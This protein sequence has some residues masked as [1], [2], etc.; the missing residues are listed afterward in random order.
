MNKLSGAGMQMLAGV[1]T[2]IA[3]FLILSLVMHTDGLLKLMGV[4]LLIIIAFV[5]FMADFLDERKEKEVLM[6]KNNENK[7]VRQDRKKPE[8]KKAC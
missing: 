8:H 2:V 1:T 7:K 3:V 5:M 6:E 4:G